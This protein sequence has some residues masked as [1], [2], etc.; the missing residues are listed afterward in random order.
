MSDL[1]ALGKS[2]RETAIAKGWEH[3][4]RT[5]GDSIALIHSEASEA[6][7]EFR[8]GHE[9]T[10][11]YYNSFET[12]PAYSNNGQVHKD[13]EGNLCKPEGIPIELADILIRVLH[14]AA[15]HGIDI[16]A[17]LKLKMAYNETRA[18]RHGGK[19]L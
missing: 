11:I 15:A 17:A 18:Y 12:Q 6:L 2:I 13:D 7:E 5:F 19:R 10:E 9:F 16:E 4:S 3:T 8:N 1:N 14:T